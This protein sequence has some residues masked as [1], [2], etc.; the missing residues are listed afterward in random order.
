M[1]GEGRAEAGLGEWGGGWGGEELHGAG[2]GAE[3]DFLGSGVEIEGDFLVHLSVGVAW[4]KDLDA[5]FRGTGEAGS[6]SEVAHAI[7][8][9]PGDVGGADAVGGG[10]GAFGEDATAGHEGAQEVGDFG[11]EAGVVGCWGWAHEDMAVA[12][13]FDAALDFGQLGVG[14]QCIPTL[15]VDGGLGLLGRQGDA[16][17]CH[18][19]RI[20]WGRAGRNSGG[21]GAGGRV[22]AWGGGLRQGSRLV[23]S[24]LVPPTVAGGRFVGRGRRLGGR[25]RGG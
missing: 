13:G 6:V 7:W 2:G 18:G 22:S 23:V 25:G 5:K 15:E 8:G 10:D 16:E 4:G 12:V 21:E 24:S 9:S 20:G 19:E 1:A 3:P 11:L 17:G 14:Q